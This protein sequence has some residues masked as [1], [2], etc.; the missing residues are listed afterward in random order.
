MVAK[1]RTGYDSNQPQAL[2]F[3]STSQTT[4]KYIRDVSLV[5]TQ[6]SV[7]AESGVTRMEIDATDLGQ[8]QETTLYGRALQELP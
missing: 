7:G 6:S 5:Q 1:D 2:F 4:F 3:S 8:S